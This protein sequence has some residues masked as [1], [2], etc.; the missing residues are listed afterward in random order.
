MDDNSEIDLCHKQIALLESHRETLLNALCEAVR[1]ITGQRPV[2][3]EIMRKFVATGELPILEQ[4]LRDEYPLA[5][6]TFTENR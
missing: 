3:S 1:I 2:A 6:A 5:E 4:E